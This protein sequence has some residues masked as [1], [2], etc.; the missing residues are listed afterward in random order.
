ML[1]NISF[2]PDAP[3][4]VRRLIQALGTSKPRHPFS[5]MLM[6]LLLPSLASALSGS[7]PAHGFA[8]KRCRGGNRRLLFLQRCG[9]GLGYVS[10][11]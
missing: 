6:P 4:A 11:I 10:N 8:C 7:R 2:N 3:Q 9:P 5:V 1:A